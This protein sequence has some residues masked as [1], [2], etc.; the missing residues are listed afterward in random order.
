MKKIT[1]RMTFPQ[2]GE[3]PLRD[4]GGIFPQQQTV[5]PRSCP[6]PAVY[7]TYSAVS[8]DTL[9]DRGQHGCVPRWQ[10]QALREGLM[11]AAHTRKAVEPPALRAGGVHT[12]AAFTFILLHSKIAFGTQRPRG[13]DEGPIHSTLVVSTHG[14]D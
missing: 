14:D 10:G 11:S 8:P 13:G 6:V 5:R 1:G 12:C 4:K 3:H 7:K 2:K 9:C